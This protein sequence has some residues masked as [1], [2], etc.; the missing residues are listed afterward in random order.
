MVD[1]EVRDRFGPFTVDDSWE[2]A[3]DA[4]YVVERGAGVF[5]EVSLRFDLALLQSVA[6]AP[7]PPRPTGTPP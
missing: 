2:L 3:T 7:A 4:S 5:T 1:S 6:T